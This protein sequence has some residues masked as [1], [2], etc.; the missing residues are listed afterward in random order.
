MDCVTQVPLI[1]ILKCFQTWSGSGSVGICDDDRSNNNSSNW[2]LLSIYFM[3]H[4]EGVYNPDLT[5]A[6][7][8]QGTPGQGLAPGSV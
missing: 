7:P 4:L 5:Q 6:F 3:L 2:D 8:Q 1:L